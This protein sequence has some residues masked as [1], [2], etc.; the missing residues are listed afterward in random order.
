PDKIVNILK[1]G[2]RFATEPL[3]RPPEMLGLVRQVSQKTNQE[4][5]ERCVLECAEGL[6]KGVG[7]KVRRMNLGAVVSFF[8]DS[9]LKLLVSDKE[10]GFVVA[11]QGLF[12]EKAGEAMLK[13]FRP[14]SGVDLKKVKA[15]AVQL[16]SNMGLDSLRKSVSAAKGLSLEAFFTVKTHKELMPLRAIVTQK[17]SW[18]V[19]VSS[20]LQRHLSSLMLDDPFVVRN[21]EALVNYLREDNP[22]SCQLV[23][24]DVED[25][26]YAI[27]H[28]EL[29]QAV[30]ECIDTFGAVAFSS[31]CGIASDS[32]LELLNF[33]LA[34]TF[35]TFE[36]NTF[37]Q[38]SGI[39]IGSNVAPVLSDIYLA[40]CDRAIAER[41]DDRVVK[42]LRYV[43][44]YLIVLKSNDNT[45]VESVIASIL[46][47]FT[48]CSPGLNF[49]AETTSEG[50]LQFLDINLRCEPSHLCWAYEPRSKKG[51]LVYESAH[52]K[53]VKRAIALSSLRTSLF[54]SCHHRCGDSFL[55]Q[56]TR[57][58]NAGFPLGVVMGVVESLVKVFRGPASTEARQKPTVRPVVLPYMHKVSHG[59]KKVA[60]RY[61]VPVVFSAPAKLGRLCAAVNRGGRVGTQCQVKHRNPF[62]ACACGV[63]YLIPLSCGKVYIGQ[64]GRCVNDRAREHSLSLRSSP[65]GNLAV[66]CD[67]CAC[68]PVFN[69]IKILARHKNKYA[70]EIDEAFFI[71]NHDA[72]KCISVPSLALVSDEMNFIRRAGKYV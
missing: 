49:K 44:D 16:C 31:S 45:D 70:R 15:R 41:L 61:N 26:F 60:S 56:V 39:C 72:G 51:L 47:V 7:R 30:E 18:Q 62:V 63:V 35:V 50:A 24:F 1:K 36:G 59:V 71:A 6:L 69:E 19:H 8:N 29:M 58:S 32:F 48:D 57:L 38:K 34:S 9:R 2:P 64:T 46:H 33:Y 4:S 17:S 5:R 66:H 25:L 22:G 54:K 68:S 65:S 37:L 55:L 40:K 53:T 20:F 11:P 27:P 10:G 14:V 43:D 3:V 28:S 12:L 13:N 52:S 21:S 67:R 42:V 23:S